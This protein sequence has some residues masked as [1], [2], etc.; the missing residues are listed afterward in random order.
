[1]KNLVSLETI[2]K[3]TLWVAKM[4][5][6]RHV[7]T[8][9]EVEHYFPMKECRDFDLCAVQPEHLK[10]FYDGFFKYTEENGFTTVQE[11]YEVY[12]E[13]S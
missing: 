5:Y 1:M 10:D 4:T 8:Y 3:D 9:E 11:Y 13:E 12:K 2:L 6:G 7:G